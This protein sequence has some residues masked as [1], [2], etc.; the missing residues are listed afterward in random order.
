MDL[1]WPALAQPRQTIV[2]YMGLLGIDILCRE[3]VAHGLPAAM[4][5]A[6]IQQGTTPEQ[7]VLVGD[8]A[9]LP[10][11]VRRGGVRAPTLIIIGEVVKLRDRLKWF[12]PE[13]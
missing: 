5:A 12:E 9:T 1:N 10:G 8:L 3:L 4:P 7:R 13:G 11:I 6:L 2:F